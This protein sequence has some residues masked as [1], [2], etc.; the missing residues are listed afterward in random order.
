[1]SAEHDLVLWAV[2]AGVCTLNLNNPMARIR[3]RVSGISPE[4]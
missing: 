4:R 3:R 1:M 2:D